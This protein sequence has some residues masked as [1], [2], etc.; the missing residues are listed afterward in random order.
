MISSLYNGYEKSNRNCICTENE[1]E[2]LTGKETVSET[3]TE[4]VTF[5]VTGAG[6]CGT[7]FVQFQSQ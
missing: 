5:N 1:T 3:V 2:T 7:V 4:A 6:E